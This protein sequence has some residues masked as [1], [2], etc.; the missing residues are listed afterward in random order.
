M[1]KNALVLLSLLSLAAPAC[2]ITTTTRDVGS[3]ST[4]GSVYLG[5]NLIDNKGNDSD[6]YDIGAQLGAYSAIRLHADKPVELGQV[7][8]VF[9]DG[10]R[11]LAPAP[12]AMN[13]DEW[14]APIPLPRGPRPIHSV[15]IAGKATTSLLARVEIYGYR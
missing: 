4:D 15:V 3:V 8:V 14:S 5:W 10:E 12:A 7:Q 2:T 9:A 11:W 6:T 1:T 13:G